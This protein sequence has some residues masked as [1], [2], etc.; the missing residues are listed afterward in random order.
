MENYLGRK[1]QDSMSTPWA[2]HQNVHVAEF[3]PVG[4][5]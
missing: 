1:R 5:K 2:G 3:S 4:R